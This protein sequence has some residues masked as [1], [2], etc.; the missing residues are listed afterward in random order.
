MPFVIFTTISCI[1]F[2]K[3]LSYLILSSF[4]N[5]TGQLAMASKTFFWLD[6]MV[7]KFIYMYLQGIVP[8]RV[9]VKNLIF[10][11]HKMLPL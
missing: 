6:L 1:M 4:F 8:E 9:I 11:M 10:Y 3:L 5:N 7:V 2:N